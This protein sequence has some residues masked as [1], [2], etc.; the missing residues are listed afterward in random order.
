MTIVVN[1]DDL[2]HIQSNYKSRRKWI[3]EGIP[4]IPEY[5]MSKSMLRPA[6]DA[7]I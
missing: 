2:H 1:N 3:A 7:L 4:L 5:Y 6:I